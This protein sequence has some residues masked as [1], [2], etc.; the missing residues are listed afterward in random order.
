MVMKY[1]LILGISFSLLFG[2]SYMSE[3]SNGYYKGDFKKITRYNMMHMTENG[4]DDGA[5]KEYDKIVEDIKKLDDASKP[6]KVT[7]VGHVYKSDDYYPHK[8]R[9]NLSYIN[10]NAEMIDDASASYAEDVENMLLDDGIKREDISVYA[11]GGYDMPYSDA[12]EEEL[13]DGVMVTLYEI[14]EKDS[15]SDG[16]GVF[17]RFDRCVDTPQGAPVDKNG[18]SLDSDHDGVFDYNDKCPGTSPVGVIVD[19]N[20][21]PLDSD[22]DGVIDYKDKCEN[23]PQGIAVDPHGCPLKQTLKLYFKR[24]SAKILQ[25]SYPEIKKF[26]EFLKANPK[27]KV[28]VT[29]H[30]DSLGKAG[31]NMKLSLERAEAVKKALVLEGVEAS[32]ITAKGRG[33]LD[34]IATN[35]TKEGRAKNRRIEVELA[36]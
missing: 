23:T 34:P 33:E 26:A 14:E 15:D 32:R 25:E 7:V 27:Y 1:I 2:S 11:V 36:Y 4:L 31:D 19:E 10:H 29:G 20:G 30:T 28:T 21:C 9:N 22:N 6:Y 3:V 18:C 5:Q 35:R 24:G 17:D 8:N 12:N 13:S 16:D